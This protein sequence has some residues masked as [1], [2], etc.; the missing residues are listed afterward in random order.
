MASGAEEKAGSKQAIGAKTRLIPGE[1]AYSPWASRSLTA[2]VS[3]FRTAMGL[4]DLARGTAKLANGENLEHCQCSPHQSP[5]PD[6]FSP[7]LLSVR[8]SIAT[9][10]S[11]CS[12][13]SLGASPAA[14][15]VLAP[16][17]Q[18]VLQ[19]PVAIVAGGVL[20][21]P[22]TQ[23]MRAAAEGEVLELAQ[24]AL[25]LR[26]RP[27]HHLSQAEL[28]LREVRRQSEQRRVQ[29]PPLGPQ[30]P[31]HPSGRIGRGAWDG[32]GLL[33]RRLFR[34]GSR[35][36]PGLRHRPYRGPAHCLARWQWLLFLLVFVFH[37]RSNCRRHCY[38]LRS[39]FYSRHLP[40]NAATRRPRPLAAM[41]T[42]R[43]LGNPEEWVGGA[44]RHGVLRHHG[45]A[46]PEI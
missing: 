10:T 34:K 31:Q 23:D 27:A 44:L 13:L 41:A 26:R 25:L 15:L 42:A 33:G 38:R 16:Q 37:L 45:Q 36:R 19:Q 18:P 32:A 4:W 40:G 12:H 30:P 28:Y 8:I 14:H 17:L 35:P 11:P 46:F 29:P 22:V 24:E 3:S 9:R 20:G 1:A 2:T 5:K 39:C 6:G 43:G 7:L 21:S